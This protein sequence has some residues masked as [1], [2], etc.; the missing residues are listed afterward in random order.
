[1]ESCADK[2]M[3]LETCHFIKIAVN[4]LCSHH[5]TINTPERF[6]EYINISKHRF[7]KLTKGITPPSFGLFLSIQ[8]ALKELDIKFAYKYLKEQFFPEY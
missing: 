3:N 2:K 6:A 4:M 7:E 1:M 8:G 5:K